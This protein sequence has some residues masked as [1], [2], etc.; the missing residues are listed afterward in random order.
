MQVFSPGPVGVIG[1]MMVKVEPSPFRLA[2]SILPPIWVTMLLAT[3]RPMPLP[4]K[5]LV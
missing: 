1:S 5:R 2:A 3:A 4:P